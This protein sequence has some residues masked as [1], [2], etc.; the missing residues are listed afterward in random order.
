MQQKPKVRVDAKS[1][2]NKWIKDQGRVFR[3]SHKEASAQ[4]LARKHHRINQSAPP[5]ERFQVGDFVRVR[6]SNGGKTEP[7]WKGPYE[8]IQV[9]EWNTYRLKLCSNFK[10]RLR[11]NHNQ[12][13]R[14]PV[15]SEAVLPH[16][17]STRSQ[18]PSEQA[19]AQP[20][21]TLFHTT[22][23]TVTINEPQ[24]VGDDSVELHESSDAVDAM[25]EGVQER[26]ELIS[27]PLTTR[28]PR[29]PAGFRKREERN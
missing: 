12:L 13:E 7:R 4:D 29:M 8:V 16:Y 23:E 27:Q 20:L 17:S 24:L 14:F 15:E 5:V 10:I 21:D 11:R 2:V 28:R 26:D 9:L 18:K 19:A 6:H 3:T 22:D 1:A 25:D